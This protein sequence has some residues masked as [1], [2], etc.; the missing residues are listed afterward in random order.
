MKEW[1]Q[2]QDAFTLHRYARKKFPRRMYTVFKMDHVW[3]SDLADMRALKTY[4]DNMTFLLIAIDVFS[5][6]TWV[7]PLKDKTSKSVATAFEKILRLGRIPDFLQ[8]DK[9]REYLGREMQDVLRKYDIRYRVVRSP[10][11]KCAVAE[12]MIR[13]LKERMWRYFTHRN[14]RRYI[15]DLQSIVQAQNH[16]VHSTIKMAPTNVNL[17][18][19]AIV[20]ERLL[21]R[22]KRWDAKMRKPKYK[23]GDLVRISN[24]K[25][26]FAKGYVG[27]W[28]KELFL[29]TKVLANQYP[30]V[31]LIKD[32]D[33]EVIDGFFYEEEL[34]LVKKDLENTE[35]E[36]DEIIRTKG[37]GAK[38]LALVSWKNYPPKFNS[39]IP[40]ANIK[41]I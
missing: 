35:F 37:S 22:K 20:R 41:D 3:E 26:V 11:V 34:G 33:G 4:N 18:T 25:G 15:D 13:T 31:Y 36:I 32:L 39:W 28:S 24:A 30:V 19:A 16:S 2:E 6:Y 8:T 27:S 7:E 29:I 1:L 38:K 14:T 9:G 21:R 40:A 10:D 5:K 17:E 23:C 12:R